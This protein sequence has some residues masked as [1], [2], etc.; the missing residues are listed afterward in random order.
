MHLSPDQQRD[1]R[2]DNREKEFHNPLKNPNFINKRAVV[3]EPNEAIH[4]SPEKAVRPRLNWVASDMHLEPIQSEEPIKT[5]EK[6]FGDRSTIS[7]PALHI[8]KCAE[9]YEHSTTMQE[10]SKDYVSCLEKFTESTIADE[11]P[12]EPIPYATDSIGVT[13]MDEEE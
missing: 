12:F 3:F 1:R 10:S 9:V 13:S 7:S 5:D 8:D 6:L 4:F 11:N 2:T